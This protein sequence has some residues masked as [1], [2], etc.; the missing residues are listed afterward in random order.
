MEHTDKGDMLF[1]PSS[2]FEDGAD[3]TNG[4]PY[5]NPNT[6]VQDKKWCDQD[7]SQ[8]FQTIV[9]MLNPG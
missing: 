9:T 5:L 4:N 7:R 1:S 8:E 2:P 3:I 6:A